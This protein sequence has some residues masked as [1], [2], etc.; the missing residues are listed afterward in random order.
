MNDCQRWFAACHGAAELVGSLERA[1][2]QGVGDLV[3]NP[4]RRQFQEAEK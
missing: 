2:R 4:G 1:A 3:A